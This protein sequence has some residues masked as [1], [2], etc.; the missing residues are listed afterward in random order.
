MKAASGPRVA[1]ALVVV[2]LCLGARRAD[3]DELPAWSIDL[4]AHLFMKEGMGWLFRGGF[5]D[6]VLAVWDDRLVSKASP[7]TLEESGLGIVVV[8]VFVHPLGVPDMRESARRQVAAAERWV[9]EHRDWV[10]ARSADE[11]RRALLT[12]RHVMVLSLEGAAGVLESEEDLVELVDELGIRIVTPL[13]IADD[14]FG[15]GALLD[16]YQYFGNPIGLADRLLDPGCEDPSQNRRGLDPPGER[17]VREL[18]ARG[19]WV[20]LSHAPDAALATLVPLLEDAGQPLLVTHGMLRRHRAAERGIPDWLLREVGKSGG[21][22][23]LVPTDDA[24]ADLTVPPAL[25]PAGC[26][27]GDCAHGA[28]AFAAIW[29]EAAAMAGRDAVVLGSD[30]N[31]GV[32]HLAPTCGT[33]TRLDTEGFR[34][35]GMSRDLWRALHDLGAPVPP[36]DRALERF[37]AAWARVRPTAT[38]AS[39]LPPLPRTRLEV[40][41]PSFE[42]GIGAGLSYGDGGDVPGALLEADV[43]IVKDAR[44]RYRP[45]PVVTLAHVSAEV[46]KAVEDDGVPYAWVRFAPIGM[47][48]R[49]LD[50]QASADALELV[51]R[52]WTALDQDASV[53]LALLAGVVRTMPGILKSPGEYQLFVELGASILGYRGILHHDEARADLHGVYMAGAALTLG[54]AV[55]P[56]PEL[57]LA[58]FGGGAADATLLATQADAVAYASDLVARAGIELGTADGAFV[59]FFEGRFA[60]TREIADEAVLVTTPRLVAGIVVRP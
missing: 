12:R 1:L 16:G 38:D 31:G 57:R 58:I 11:A 26:S 52:R 18:V 47:E 43:R 7:A 4:H 14:A 20:D 48:A 17:L 8:S 33:G 54:A 50:D 40:A 22:V 32:R 46:T 29:S 6:P 60:A 44:G 59:Q 9:R 39:H 21:V 37:L 28:S 56:G 10:I 45:T 42:L 2:A 15:G 53:R 27:A 3:A 30:V 23:G 41:G 13:H 24:F 49:W 36:L 35:I 19:V 55:Y 51:V 34:H 25:C 5:E